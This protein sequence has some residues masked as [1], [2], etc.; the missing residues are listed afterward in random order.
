MPRKTL[1]LTSEATF[2]KK[3]SLITSSFHFTFG[4]IRQ[5]VS[6]LLLIAFNVLEY[7]F[8]YLSLYDSPQW[9]MKTNPR[10]H[11]CFDSQHLAQSQTHTLHSLNILYI[12]MCFYLAILTRICTL[13]VRKTF[14]LLSIF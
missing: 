1:R 13:P 2:S 3:L 5:Q 14:P 10:S 11:S 4:W 6:V 8:L 7:K 9:T 12:N